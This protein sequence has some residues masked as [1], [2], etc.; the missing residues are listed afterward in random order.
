MSTLIREGLRSWRRTPV[1]ASLTVLSLALGIGALTACY[2]IV[3]ALLLRS[4]DVPHARRLVTLTTDEQPRFG[5]V[6]FDV[7]E[8]LQRR[9]SLCEACYAW[10]S[11]SLNVAPRGAVEMRQVTWASGGVFKALGVGSAAIGRLFD[12]HDDVRGGGPDGAV[13]VIG[14]DFWLGRYGGAQDV[15]GRTIAIERTP[16]TIIGVAPRSLPGLAV[17]ARFDAI[18]PLQSE[19]LVL[20]EFSTVTPG[21]A[22]VLNVVFR[23]PTGQRAAALTAALRAEQGPIRDATMPSS[24]NAGTSQPGFGLHPRSACEQ[25]RCPPRVVA[26][27]PR[28][29]ECRAASVAE[30]PRP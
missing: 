7:W 12:E 13:V 14:H 21:T 30:Q 17:G 5:R 19:P 11:R 2:A 25:G 29:P 9:A 6:S 28:A 16:F 4:L 23:L 27:Q 8:Q 24:T 1:V 15:V 18:A 26:G 3:D 20:R 22:P 10:M